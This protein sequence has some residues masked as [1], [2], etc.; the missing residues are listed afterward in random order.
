MPDITLQQLRSIMPRLNSARAQ[1]CLNWINLA[2]AEFHIDTGLRQAAFL[3]QLAHESG[4]LRYMQELWGP[5]AA[6]LRYEGRKDLGNTQKGDGRRY[7]GRGPIQITGRANYRL[8]GKLIGLPLEEI[9]VMA[10]YLDVGFRI[11]GAFWSRNGLN[12]LADKKAFEA[13]TRKI[14]GGYNGLREREEFYG[15]ALRALPC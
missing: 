14:N 6:Q 11:A 1:E 12:E 13:I 8:Y 2:M 15:L 4:E 7:L 10:A 9:P 5:T 3:A